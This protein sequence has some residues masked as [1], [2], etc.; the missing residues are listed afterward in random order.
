MNWSRFKFYCLDVHRRL[1]QG[2]AVAQAFDSAQQ[3]VLA[4][5]LGP[6][7][8]ANTVPGVLM[9]ALKNANSAAAVKQSVE[10]YQALDFSELTAK[11]SRLRRVGIY[12]TYLSVL[13]LLFSS[14]YA[15]FVIPKMFEMVADLALTLPDSYLWFAKFWNFFALLIFG[16]LLMVFLINRTLNHLFEYRHQAEQSWQY[17]LLLPRTIKQHYAALLALL[18]L[19][20]VLYHAEAAAQ[21][22]AGGSE[23]SSEFVSYFQTEQY[24]PQTMADCLALLLQAHLENL[25]HAAE[26]YLRRLYV[27]IT[28]LVIS[29]IFMF[30]SSAYAPIF[31]MGDG[32]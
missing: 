23:A 11:P 17:R 18:K 12:I 1:A 19:P 21:E 20:F 7:L 2:Q 29:S 8:R 5:H 32:I 6:D 10:I 15:V 31:M 13:Y 14:I 30:I 24:S 3:S 26:T 4:H 27:T 28:L 22:A 9:T 25:V 16:L